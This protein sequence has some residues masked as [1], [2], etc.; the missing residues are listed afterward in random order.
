M[1]LLKSGQL[2]EAQSSIC[3]ALEDEPD[4]VNYLLL[5]G[6]IN[7]A[8][9][10]FG[11]ASTIYHRILQL[12]PEYAAGWNNLG[13][14]YHALQRFDEAAQ[15]F[16]KSLHYQGDHF[17]PY[18]NMLL[19]NVVMG[20]PD[21]ALEIYPIAKWL[22][23][24]DGK[25]KDLK[26]NIALAL[27]KKRM[28]KPGWEAFDSMLSKVKQRKELFYGDAPYWDGRGGQC[29]VAYGEQGIGDEIMGA[30]MI[31]DLSEDCSV[32]IDCDNRLEGLFKR[33]F[34]DCTV[35]GTRF[36]KTEKEWLANHRVDA[37]VA[38]LSLG[39]W[40]RQRDEDFPREPYLKACPVRR[41]M[42]RH[43]LSQYPGRKM[44]LA[45]TGGLKNTNKADRSLTLEQ[46]QP[47][48]SIPGITWV[49][50]EYKGGDPGHGIK[51]FPWI[52]QTN[53]YDDTAALVA[54]LD[55][56]VSVTTAVALL[57]GAIGQQCHVLVPE[58]PTWHWLES[59]EMP[60]FP[61]KLHRRV[62]NDWT[63]LI[64]SLAEELRGTT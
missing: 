21:K 48:L 7:T 42:Y 52:T 23:D 9:N 4:N 15:C 12:N 35:Y 45:W 32:I 13:H 39:R 28:W 14:C 11:F 55:G 51:H 5:A 8:A 44:G 36:Q 33:S 29:V 56:V 37:R 57:A 31:P 30:S 10:R 24:D 49:N 46:L 16:A 59:G 18:N 41:D 43:L 58:H 22:A 62:G 19:I 26:S 40:Y 3:K 20:N 63:S 38:V 61:L 25:M 2:D 53:D 54:E 34:P 50:L 60:W 27:L 64:D 6:N 1:G 17:D 47:L